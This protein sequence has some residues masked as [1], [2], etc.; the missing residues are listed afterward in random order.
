MQTLSNFSMWLTKFKVALIEK[1]ATAF[2]ELLND[3]PKPE[4]A[5]EAQEALFLCQEALELMHLLKEETATS[6]KQM[7]KN[8]QFLHATERPKVRRLDITS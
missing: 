1:D 5:I 2:E 6:L 7:E 3:I 8:L 4:G